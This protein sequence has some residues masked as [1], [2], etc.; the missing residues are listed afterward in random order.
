MKT[1]N[2]RPMKKRTTEELK[3]LLSAMRPFEY[4]LNDLHKHRLNEIRH[5]LNLRL[6]PVVRFFK[7]L[8]R[9]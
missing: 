5:E 8:V 6:N 7:G 9:P 1:A 2:E 4:V 3:A